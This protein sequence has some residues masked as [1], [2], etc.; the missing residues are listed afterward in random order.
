MKRISSVTA[1]VMGLFLAAGCSA[2]SGDSS[3]GSN[4]ANDVAPGG[5]ATLSA[6]IIDNE[7]MTAG[8][9]GVDADKNGIRD[10]IDRLIAQKYALTPAMKK[11]AE[12]K[13]RALQKAIEATTRAESRAAGDQMM[14]A[15][16]CSLKVFP[17][18]SA[19]D[20]QFRVQMSKD[21]EALTANTA[22]RF[23]AYWNGE[24][25]GGSTVYLQPE[26]PVCD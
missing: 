8:L 3:S 22:E 1:M 13:A 11:A 20:T 24:K 10:D 4:A 19:K 26:E 7:D 25:L 9:K 21:I 2:G 12:Q 18:G 5:T 14:R 15:S 6:K 16:R 17:R 23:K